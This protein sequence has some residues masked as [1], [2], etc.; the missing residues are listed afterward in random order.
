MANPG[1][2]SL[3]LHDDG[4]RT[5]VRELAERKKMSQNEFIET[6]VTREVVM[7]GARVAVDLESAAK[8]LRELTDEQY[9]ALVSRSADEF[10]YGE[11]GPDPLQATAFHITDFERPLSQDADP[12]GI[13][14][15]FLVGLDAA[16]EVGR[17]RAP[18]AGSAGTGST[19]ARSVEPI[20]SGRTAKPSETMGGS[21]VAAKSARGA[22]SAASS[23][24]GRV[25]GK[26]ARAAKSLK[27]AGARV[28]S[29][30]SSEARVVSA[31]S[32][33]DHSAAKSTGGGP[34]ASK[35]SR[36]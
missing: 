3:R 4:L 9:A 2:F 15:A 22:S 8:R 29:E 19:S 7:L 27:S 6:A 18:G 20:K 30:K 11:S 5:L 25:A 24:G 36:R 35:S 28:V 16:A 14:A 12:F 10:A 34:A 32:A 17:R 1:T 23:S 31:R 21:R 33:G 26:S 13:D